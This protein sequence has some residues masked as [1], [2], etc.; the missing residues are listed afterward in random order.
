MLAKIFK[1]A[2]SLILLVTS[3]FANGLEV[4]SLLDTEYKPVKDPKD[5]CKL[6]L[7]ESLRYHL[8]SVAGELGAPEWVKPTSK[9]FKTSVYNVIPSEIVRCMLD[10]KS[11]KHGSAEYGEFKS[12]EFKIMEFLEADGFVGLD[13]Y[14]EANW[15]YFLFMNCLNM[16]I[17]YDFD[18]SETSIDTVVDVIKDTDEQYSTYEGKLNAAAS[19]IKI[20]MSGLRLYEYIG[21]LKSALTVSGEKPG[22]KPGNFISQLPGIESGAFFT[23]NTT[24]KFSVENTASFCPKDRNGSVQYTKYTEAGNSDTPLSHKKI[25]GAPCGLKNLGETCYFNA[26]MQFLYASEDFR[27]LI[28][29]IANANVA[30]DEFVAVIRSG[31]EKILSQ[32]NT[33][34]EQGSSG[35]SLPDFDYRD[36]L[37]KLMGMNVSEYKKDRIEDN[38][39]QLVTPLYDT[40]YTYLKTLQEQQEYAKLHKQE[41]GID[42]NFL[43]AIRDLVAAITNIANA[44]YGEVDAIILDDLFNNMSAGT[45]S[46]TPSGSDSKSKEFNRLY[47]LLNGRMKYSMKAQNDASEL[48]TLLIGDLEIAMRKLQESNIKMSGNT[49]YIDAYKEKFGCQRTTT[50]VSSEDKSLK[51]SSLPESSAMLEFG[52]HSHQ[53]G[54]IQLEKLI[55]EYC[56]DKDIVEYDFGN[57]TVAAQKST[58]INPAE[59]LILYVMRFEAGSDRDHPNKVNTPVAYHQEMKINV[60]PYHLRAT[61][62]HRGDLT[63]GHYLAKAFAPDGTYYVAN[64]DK[65]TTLSS[66]TPTEDDKKTVY[67]LMYEKAK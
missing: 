65:I 9:K 67:L 30:T 42:S 48:L 66:T 2:F 58:T 32:L 12:S 13:K 8:N 24:W 7:Q 10:I 54:E 52:M 45:R 57:G 55:E 38:V 44:V 46:Y 18:A 34:Y 60:T 16:M 36:K 25:S 15:N 6:A 3:G 5:F 23:D 26:T 20:Y 62:H 41:S 61:I 43:D 37:S 51:S 59:N 47:K 28:E 29:N 1:L 39:I 4:V 17:N 19:D 14:T 50:V 33:V 49:E 22:S 35:F 56:S 53:T 40:Y 31:A 11:Y 64:D 27:E 63:S 21:E